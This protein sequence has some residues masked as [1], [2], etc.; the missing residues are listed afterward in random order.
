MASLKSPVAAAS[1]VV[2]AS[3][4]STWPTVAGTRSSRSAST[5]RF[6]SSSVPVPVIGSATVATVWSELTSSVAWPSNR[7]GALLGLRS[8]E[9]IADTTSRRRHVVGLDHDHLHAALARE[10]GLDAVVGLHHLQVARV[11][12]GTAQVVCIPSAGT[13]SA[14][15]TPAETSA[16]TSGRRSTRSSTRDQRPSLADPALE[17]ADERHAA[18][19]DPVAELRQQGRQHGQR[20]DHRDGDDHDRAGR[21][22]GEIRDPAQVHPG[23]RDHHG[24]AGDE[25]RAARGRR[26]GLDGGVVAPV[27]R[28]APRAPAS[29]RTGCSPR[30]R[31]CRR[32]GRRASPTRRP[33]RAGSPGRA[34]RAWRPR[35]SA[36]AAAGCRPRP[37]RRTRTP[38]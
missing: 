23:H 9:S 8:S 19:V 14:T 28:R 4:P 11:V 22:R 24:E 36:R 2:Y 12:L 29:G 33:A 18:L 13:A 21:E 20:A 5:A 16:E 38:G 6:D 3:T 15:S 30:P 7:P 27:R 32:A 25:H 17:A 31:P 26:G 37:A 34:G 1:P 35:W 10:G